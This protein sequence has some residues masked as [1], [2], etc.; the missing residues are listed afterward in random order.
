MIYTRAMFYSSLTSSLVGRSDGSNSLYDANFGSSLLKPNHN[1]LGAYQ[2]LDF[3]IG[4]R[5]NHRVS[6][7][8]QVGKVLSKHYFDAFGYLSLPLTFSASLRLTFG[9]G[10]WKLN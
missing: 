6:T 8:A 3:G 5:I 10:S 4:C 9:E 7:F 2:P 1:V